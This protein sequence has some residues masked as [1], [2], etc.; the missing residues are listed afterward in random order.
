MQIL[1]SMEY[2]SAHAKHLKYNDYRNIKM[3]NKLSTKSKWSNLIWYR[4][5]MA[6]K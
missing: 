2:S 3:M 5:A 4:L 6:M 1:I